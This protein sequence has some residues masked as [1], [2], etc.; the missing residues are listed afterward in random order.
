[1]SRKLGGK[2]LEIETMFEDCEHRS[3]KLTDWE[4]GFIDSAYR[5]FSDTSFLSEKQEAILEKIWNRVTA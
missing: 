4:T 3:E 1:M 5:Q 2:A